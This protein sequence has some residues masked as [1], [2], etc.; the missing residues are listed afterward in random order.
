MPN[1]QLATLSSLRDRSISTLWAK[2]PQ[3]HIAMLTREQSVEIAASPEVVFDLIH[4]Y[5]RRL[6]WDPFLKKAALLNRAQAAGVGVHSLCVAKNRLGG[7]GMETVYV[8]FDRPRIA[9]VKMVRGP[10]ILQSFGASLRQD[11]V[12][13]ATTRVTYKY[14]LETRPS[15]LRWLL[16][17][18]CKWV[19]S[20]ETR[21]RL[22]KL[23]SFLEG[24]ANTRSPRV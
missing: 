10:A 17:P 22:E 13:L 16:T 15:W 18:L 7:L 1:S 23:K 20:H 6:E 9:A 19:F 14:T 3:T 5:S 24:A 4:N 12:A 8:V 11:R 2:P 21:G